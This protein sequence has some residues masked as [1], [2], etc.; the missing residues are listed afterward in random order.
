MKQIALRR[1]FLLALLAGFFLTHSGPLMAADPCQEDIK[2]FC[3]KVKPGQGG[4]GK[5]LQKHEFQLSPAC[6]E[7]RRELKERAD[8]FR[9]ACKKDVDRYCKGIKG[10]RA[11][12][13]TCLESHEIQL[14]PVCREYLRQLSKRP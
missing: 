9:E 8:A 10:G 11:N 5:C 14:G 13:I 4:V 3:K 7:R 6:A 2:K 12:V 1:T